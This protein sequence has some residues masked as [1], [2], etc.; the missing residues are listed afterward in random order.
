MNHFLHLIS[1][2][3]IILRVPLV[4]KGKGKTERFDLP[5]KWK[6]FR[7]TITSV[8]EFYGM[9]WRDVTSI[10]GVISIPSPDNY[11][12]FKQRERLE[13]EDEST[14]RKLES[15]FTGG[16]EFADFDLWDFSDGV[17]IPIRVTEG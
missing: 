6:A 7:T 11:M 9:R 4:K 10:E 16:K 1:P 14:R 8:L 5:L 12:F 2:E 15:A 13:Q 17:W 3:L